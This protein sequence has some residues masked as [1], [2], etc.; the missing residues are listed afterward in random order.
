M[1][2]NGKILSLVDKM[3]YELITVMRIMEG[4]ITA[5]EVGTY[6]QPQ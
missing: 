3:M 1:I 4:T 5:S 2:S 6:I